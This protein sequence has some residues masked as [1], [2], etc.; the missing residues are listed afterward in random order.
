M[1]IF[2][3]DTI[4][5]IFSIVNLQGSSEDNGQVTETLQSEILDNI[6]STD[7]SAMEIDEQS[8][9]DDESVEEIVS[10]DST[11]ENISNPSILTPYLSDLLIKILFIMATKIRHNLTYTAAEDILLLTHLLG[12]VENTHNTKY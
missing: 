3:F 8:G 9:S 12:A 1:L 2:D 6:H 5:N 11:M 10:S 7:S 4:T